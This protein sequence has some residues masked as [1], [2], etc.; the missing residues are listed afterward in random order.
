MS[1][2]PP[3]RLDLAVEADLPFVRT[4]VRRRTVD[5]TNA[6]AKSLLL[7]GLDDLPLLVW[8]DTQRLGKGQRNSQWWS[9]E[10]SL[11]F[12]VGVNPV[13]HGLRISQEPR[14]SLVMAVAV[15][16]A[17]KSSGWPHPGIGIRWP[18]D[19]EVGG[20]KLGGILPERVETDRGHH[21]V[22]GVGL[23]VLTHLDQ[24]PL[25]IQRIATS[26][27]ALDSRSIE[28][29]MPRLL[30]QILDQFG[31]ELKALRDDLPEQAR[32]WDGLN[33]LRN[34]VVQVSLGSRIIS[35]R[36][37]AIDAQ[38]ALCLTEAGTSQ[39]H[40]LFGGQVLRDIVTA[41]GSDTGA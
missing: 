4:I 38:G 7:Q 28:Q 6:L 17:I 13:T 16:K 1:Q 10:G 32:E 35:G 15:I 34:Q 36:I 37:K 22:I 9:D 20:R 11:T 29:G 8:A 14:L 26:L 25:E 31:Q 3:E 2:F 24:A 33:L 5:S 39:A 27:A 19:I 41:T 21:V 23:N 40:R 12:T 18:N 30:A